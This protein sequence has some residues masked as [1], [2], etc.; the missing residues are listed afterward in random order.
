MHNISDELIER[1]AAGYRPSLERI[2]TGTAPGVIGKSLRPSKVLKSLAAAVPPERAQEM[3]D[4]ATRRAV[5]THHDAEG[6]PHF[7]DYLHQRKYL[8]EFGMHN[9][10]DP[11]AGSK[12][13]Q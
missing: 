12:P 4:E 7:N 2:E 3:T 9:K 13:Y 11:L 10:E 6:R 5:P 8:K 1:I